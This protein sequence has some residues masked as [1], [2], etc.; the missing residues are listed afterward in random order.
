MNAYERMV[1]ACNGDVERALAIASE[2]A[3]TSPHEP[4]AQQSP[5]SGSGSPCGGIWDAHSES[6]DD[7]L[8]REFLP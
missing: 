8:W 4:D 5:D 6:G 7:S 1:K 2:V 3:R